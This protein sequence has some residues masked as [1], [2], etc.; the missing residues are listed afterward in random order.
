L[1]VGTGEYTIV[2]AAI[3]TGDVVTVD[4]HMEWDYDV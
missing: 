2:G 1:P 3:T 4:D